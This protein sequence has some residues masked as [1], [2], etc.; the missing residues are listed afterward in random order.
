MRKPTLYHMRPSN[1][2][3]HGKIP[4]LMLNGRDDFQVPLESSQIPLI[5][6][7]GTPDKDR[8]HALFDGGHL[9]LPTRLD[10]VKEARWTGPTATCGP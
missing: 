1:F 9:K 6:S 10:F 7:F 3:P 4:I 8:R 2:A 5:H